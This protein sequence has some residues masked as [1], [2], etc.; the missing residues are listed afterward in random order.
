LEERTLLS[1]TVTVFANPPGTEGAL[2]Q[3]TVA[4]VR[5]STGSASD[6]T[7]SINWGDGTITSAPVLPGN[8][9]NTVSQLGTGHVNG[10]HT[11][12]EEGT[13]TVAVTVTGDGQSGSGQNS[14]V[15]N[16]AALTAGTLTVP[17]VKEG[18]TFSGTVFA[19]TDADPNGTAG[20]YTATIKWGDGTSGSGTVAAGGS[21]FIVTGSHTYT[22]EF[23][24]GTFSVTVTDHS[25]TTGGSGTI[26]VT[27]APPVVNGFSGGTINEGTA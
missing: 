24:G 10:S 26:S 15:V 23:T 8:V 4:N 6:Y 13:Y 20:D 16:D 3:R 22:D 25:A 21:G 12:L 18:Q 14:L 9:G 11:Y 1:I 2:V 7:A 17:N 5:Y 27:D 19:F